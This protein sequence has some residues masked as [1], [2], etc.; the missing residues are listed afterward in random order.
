MD[1]EKPKQEELANLLVEKHRNFVKEYRREYDILDRIA[2]LKEKREQLL[3]WIDDS[4]DNPEAHQKHL[5]AKANTDNEV[6]KLHD[7]LKAMY[8]SK[9]KRFGPPEADAKGRHKW[10]KGQITANEEAENFWKNKIIEIQTSG[11]RK[12]K[13]AEAAK[14]AAAVAAQR[15]AKLVKKTHK[16]MPKAGKHRKKAVKEKAEKGH[17]SPVDKK[18]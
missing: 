15:K 11:T 7:E 1:F 16:K 2:V 17:D 4:K 18:T 8:S 9:T 14:Q 3:Y 12:E 5:T 10:L 13:D 6:V